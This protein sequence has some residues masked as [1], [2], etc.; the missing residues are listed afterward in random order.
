VCCCNANF[1]VKQCDN[2]NHENK[3]KLAEQ[4]YNLWWKDEF[5]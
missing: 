3:N 4:L 2:G 1:G 5:V